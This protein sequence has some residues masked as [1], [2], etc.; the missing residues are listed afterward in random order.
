MALVLSSCASLGQTVNLPLHSESVGVAENADTSDLL[1]AFESVCAKLVTLGAE[2][3]G[4]A[5]QLRD[6]F[7][8]QYCPSGRG[9]LDG[10][11]CVEYAGP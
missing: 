4:L 8:W 1:A 11:V 10:S 6:T 9:W 5:A 2:K 3:L 7:S